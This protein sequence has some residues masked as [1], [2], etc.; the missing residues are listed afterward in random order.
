ML[1]VTMNYWF[2]VLVLLLSLAIV[3]GY[4]WIRGAKPS[5]RFGLREH[6]TWEM[7]PKDEQTASYLRQRFFAAI[8]VMPTVALVLNLLFEGS[9]SVLCKTFEL[10]IVPRR[11]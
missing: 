9:A 11:W 6:L 1:L 5:R 3:H 7:F 8:L 10:L 2:P 4:L